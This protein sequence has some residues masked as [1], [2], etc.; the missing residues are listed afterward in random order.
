MFPGSTLGRHH[1][2]IGEYVLIPQ[3]F[4]QAGEFIDILLTD[5]SLEELDL[6][7]LYVGKENVLYCA[8][9]NG[10]FPARFS[11]NSYYQ[12]AEFIEQEE[13]EHSFF[14]NLNNEK[15][16]INNNLF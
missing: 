12:L 7:T 13:K 15:Y 11:R 6:G 1:F 16:L 14:I 3:P 5:D 2:E 9:K 8:V 4:P 10:R